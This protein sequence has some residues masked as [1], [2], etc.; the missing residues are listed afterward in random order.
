MEKE[1]E[2]RQL[3]ATQPIQYSPYNLNNL[4]MVT[5]KDAYLVF[6]EL[7]LITFSD[8]QVDLDSCVTYKN[9]DHQLLML[10]QDIVGNI[11]LTNVYSFKESFRSN[12]KGINLIIQ[13]DLEGCPGLS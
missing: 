5:G 4:T 6:L 1:V 2:V 7:F 10:L 9:Q 8:M 11:D 3:A 12:I 13:E